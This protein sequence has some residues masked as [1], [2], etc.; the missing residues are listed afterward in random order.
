MPKTDKALAVIE[1]NIEIY[2]VTVSGSYKIANKD[3]DRQSINIIRPVKNPVFGYSFGYSRDAFVPAEYNLAEIG[4]IEDVENMV[5]QAFKKKTGLMFKEGYDFVG[6]N[7]EAVKYIKKR[8]KQIEQVSGLPNQVL[9]RTVG[10]DLIRLSNAFL[11]KVRD[12]KS[13]GGKVRRLQSGKTVNPVAAYF[14][15]PAETVEIKRDSQTNKIEKYKQIM[16]DGRFREYSPDDVVHLYYDK[17]PGFNTG[18]PTIIPT[19]DDIR[20][21]RRIEQNIE[22]LVYQHLFPL[23]HHKVGTKEQPD[24]VYP[25]GTKEVD[26]VRDMIEYMPSEGSIV[27]SYRHEVSAIGAESRAIKAE[28]YLEHFKK[29]VIAG[30]GISSVDLGEGDTATRNTSDAM[31][32]AIIDE[33]KDFQQTMAVFF[34]EL[35]IMEL[36]LESSFN[37]D[38]FDDINKVKLSFNEI[39]I[40]SKIKRENHNMLLYQGHGIG[41]TEF[42]NELGK[43]AINDTERSDMYFNIIEKEKIILE[44]KLQLGFQPDIDSS[45]TSSAKNKQQPSN[46][47]GTNPGPEKRKSSVAAPSISLSDS[48]LKKEFGDVI[49]DMQKAVAMGTFSID[50]SI[51]LLNVIE[52]RVIDR[53]KSSMNKSM[54]SGVKD[55]VSDPHNVELFTAYSQV[56]VFANARINGIINTIKKVVLNLDKNSSTLFNDISK[57]YQSLSFRFD[58]ILRTEQRRA[59]LFGK[60]LGYKHV[61]KDVVIVTTKDGSCDACQSSKGS[62]IE[63]SSARL[64]DMPVAHDNCGCEFI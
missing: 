15:I 64:D 17:R 5:R 50:W 37:I 48:V 20:A 52:G 18:K 27:T 3:A 62:R 29:R 45:A 13:S 14:P 33:V 11:C 42:R 31:S 44:S 8:M 30:L 46:Q 58:F 24:R 49:S 40:D 60:A 53:L 59:Y 35:I 38:L 12:K 51:Q 41:E 2:P 34:N 36:M 7:K 25:D 28:G 9:M 63:L 6:V 1:D 19:I 54:R 32:R 61:G 10:S 56:D 55:T 26:E 4:R 22:M 57:I 43:E 47:Y 16:P 39:D 23:F 21:L